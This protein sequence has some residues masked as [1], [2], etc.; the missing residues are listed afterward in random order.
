MSAQL[1]Q[2]LANQQNEL[3]KQ[4]QS[5]LEK[6]LLHLEYQHKSEMDELHEKMKKLDNEN[7]EFQKEIER[8][9]ELVDHKNSCVATVLDSFRQ[10]I[11]TSPGFY[12]GQSEFVLKDLVPLV[13]PPKGK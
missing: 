9:N 3:N 12:E 2:S 10:F 11:E 1:R 6:E 13:A 5:Q 4:H 8:L 7:K